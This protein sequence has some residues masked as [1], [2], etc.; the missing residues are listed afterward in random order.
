MSEPAVTIDFTVVKEWKRYPAY[1][2]SG[3]GWLGEV[4]EGWDVK[5]LS[6]ICTITVSNA[7]KKTE[8]GEN[9]I[10]LCNYIDV[11]KNERVD[12]TFDFMCASAKTSEISK[13]KLKK[14][15]VIITKDSETREDIASPAIVV[16][17][18]TN[19]ICGYHLAILRPDT[20]TLEGQYLFWVLSSSK[21]RDQFVCAANGVTRFGLTIS[22]I[23][24]ALSYVPP[25]PQQR[26]IA[27][28]LNRETARIDALVEKKRRLIDLLKEKR[29]ALI[30]R[31][32]T[33]GLDPS[34]EMKDS[35]VEW[36]GEVPVGWNVIK[37]GQLIDSID[38]GWSPQAEDRIAEIDEWA[39][40]KL[41]AVSK[42]K[43]LPLEHKVLT[44]DYSPE[45]RWTINIGDFLIT[46]SN[47]PDLVGDVCLVDQTGNR[48]LIIS[49]L[50]FKLNYNLSTVNPAYI[51]YWMLSR[52]GRYQIKRDARGSSRSMVK[53]SQG[54]VKAWYV[55]LPPL[56]EQHAI[57][58]FL[59]R[60]TSRIDT[61][62]DTI[63][64]QIEKLQEYRTA[65]ISAAV[66]GRIDVR[67]EVEVT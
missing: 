45:D 9:P 26:A 51:K 65:L 14:D 24:S 11:W 48:K 38:Q 5:K 42:G 39:V 25:I 64:R 22:A 6:N 33:K 30:T 55:V 8:D 28:F 31:A 4:P 2:D 41:N 47:T 44:G 32:V 21:I 59:D 50:V 20:V 57:T 35:G 56:L 58:S 52:T 36:L 17:D 13:F 66:T 49:D 67:E 23:K 16:E 53:I 27:A 43:F 60:E 1:K 61:I 3:V 34:V 29:Q 62:I 15:D 46:R 10:L 19:V 54:I 12:N 18:L 63:N 7:D 40:I 37:H